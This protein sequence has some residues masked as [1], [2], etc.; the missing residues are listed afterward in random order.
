MLYFENK[1][2]CAYVKNMLDTTKN[3]FKQQQILRA[4]GFFDDCLKQYGLSVDQ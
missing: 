3:N 4:N 2:K 1:S